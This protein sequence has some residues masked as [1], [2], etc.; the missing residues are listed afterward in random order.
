MS[1]DLRPLLYQ[2]LGSPIGLLLRTSDFARARQRLYQARVAAADQDL[3]CLQF[4]A[5][6]GIEGGDLIIVKETVQVQD[7]QL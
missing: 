5:S 7:P 1:P 4:R 6:P 3:A 2:A